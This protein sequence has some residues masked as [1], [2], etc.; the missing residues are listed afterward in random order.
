MDL[1]NLTTAL[2]TFSAPIESQN[3][4]CRL[5]K[6]VHVLKNKKSAKFSKILTGKKLLRLGAE[7]SIFQ[8]RKTDRKSNPKY[9]KIISTKN[10]TLFKKE[11]DGFF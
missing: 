5:Q 10:K 11:S 9:K 3:L 2:F 8:L 4:F 6:S 7:F 1:Y